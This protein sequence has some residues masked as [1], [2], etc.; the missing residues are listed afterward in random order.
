MGFQ[1][2]P[3]S[4]WRAPHL[5]SRPF[6]RK[7]VLRPKR[8]AAAESIA[9]QMREVGKGD[10]KGKARMHDVDHLPWQKAIC[11]WISCASNH[12]KS[13][14]PGALRKGTPFQIPERL[15]FLTNQ[16]IPMAKLVSA[17]GVFFGLYIHVYSQI[18]L[19][20]KQ[21]AVEHKAR[22]ASPSFPRGLWLGIYGSML[23]QTGRS[24]QF[25]FSTSQ[26]TSETNAQAS[27]LCPKGLCWRW[28]A[29]L[30]EK[31]PARIKWSMS[32]KLPTNMAKKISLEEL[33]M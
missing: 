16:N 10:Q 3:N 9:Q 15:C 18:S 23:K 2:C 17:R 5:A 12:L 32:T 25:L 8:Q 1:T 14:F 20:L 19:I 33:L 28:V 21:N 31:D 13:F 29:S 30:K 7:D 24:V 11:F 6:A 27:T 26:V 4:R 22:I